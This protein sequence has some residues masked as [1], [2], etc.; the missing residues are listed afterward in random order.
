MLQSIDLLP[1]ASVHKC[2][3]PLVDHLGK[4]STVSTFQIQF[5]EDKQMPQSAQL[6]VQMF[7]F[8]KFDVSLS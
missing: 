5:H 6:V 8:E 1:C 3:G 2:D 4:C 7:H